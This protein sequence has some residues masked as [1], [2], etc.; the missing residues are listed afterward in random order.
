MGLRVSWTLNP[1]TTS[2]NVVESCLSR[3]VYPGAWFGTTTLETELCLTYT[4]NFGMSPL[5]A[6]DDAV[7]GKPESEDRFC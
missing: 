5:N 1:K 6:E 7:Y 4:V 3:G 2:V